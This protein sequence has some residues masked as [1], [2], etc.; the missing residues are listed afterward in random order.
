M[1]VN[2]ICRLLIPCRFHMHPR[3]T[4]ENM[5]IGNLGLKSFCAPVRYNGKCLKLYESRSGNGDGS[6]GRFKVNVWSPSVFGRKSTNDTVRLYSLL[7]LLLGLWCAE[8]ITYHT[9]TH[10]HNTLCR[11]NGIEAFANDV[12]PKSTSSNH[13][14]KPCANCVD[15]LHTLSLKFCQYFVTE[16][17]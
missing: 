4:Y 15:A 10:M 1:G 6:N 14:F 5:F 8:Y 2:S 9:H 17:F 7:L 11:E 13:A 12:L 16:C 3:H